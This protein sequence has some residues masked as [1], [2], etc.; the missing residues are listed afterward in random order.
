M[1]SAMFDA[2]ILLLL[3]LTPTA[4]VSLGRGVYCA[5]FRPGMSW[6]HLTE[7]YKYQ[8]P[9]PERLKASAFG[10]WPLSTPWSTYAAFMDDGLFLRMDGMNL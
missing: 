5:L 7:V 4:L 1:T 9:D 6:K 8:G 3:V 2:L 10:L